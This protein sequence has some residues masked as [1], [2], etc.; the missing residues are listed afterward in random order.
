MNIIQHAE[1]LDAYIDRVN[2]PRFSNLLRVRFINAAIGD[3]MEDRYS[4][5]RNRKG[6]SFETIQRVRDELYTLVKIKSPMTATG[7]AYPIAQFPTDY[8]YGLV[9]KV[10]INS[11]EYWA[12]PYMYNMKPVMNLDPF[13]RPKLDYPSRVYF[14]QDATGFTLYFGTT[15]VLGNGTLD[16]LKLPNTCVY[17]IERDSTY[18]GPAGGIACIA[19]EPLVYAATSYAIGATFTL[20]VAT[21]ITSPVGGPA[22]VTGF[23]NSDMPATLDEEIMKRASSLMLM[24]IS[25]YN[26]EAVIERSSK[27]T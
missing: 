11:V 13:E 18:V 5:I 20:A 12:L 24:S 2:S 25:D 3:I 16:Y 14:M 1:G 4:N 9:M 6:Y 23:T 7:N 22:F 26:K 19:I 21:S 8:K 17:G 27:E 15:G 10:L